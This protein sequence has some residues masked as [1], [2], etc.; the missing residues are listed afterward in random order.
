[1]KSHK[2]FLRLYYFRSKDMLGVKNQTGQFS[3][4]PTIP[5]L[6]PGNTGFKRLVGLGVLLPRFFSCAP[7]TITFTVALTLKL[8]PTLSNRKLNMSHFGLKVLL[9]IQ[10]FIVHC[11]RQ[12]E[13]DRLQLSSPHTT[14]R[15]CCRSWW[16]L[17]FF[18]LAITACSVTMATTKNPHWRKW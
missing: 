8:D 7:T 1:M 18:Q 2:S 6:L 15:C 12:G 13:R 5:L 16:W 10:R 11:F 17:D 3:I 9:D 4:I 14:V